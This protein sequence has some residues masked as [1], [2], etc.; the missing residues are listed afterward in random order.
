MVFFFIQYNCLSEFVISTYFHIVWIF[1]L[2]VDISS[3]H[4]YIL[5]LIHSINKIAVVNKNKTKIQSYL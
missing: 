2:Q 1:S 5:S 4:L 3:Q